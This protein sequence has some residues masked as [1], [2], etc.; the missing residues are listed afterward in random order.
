[1]KAERGWRRFIKCEVLCQN[2][3]YVAKYNL[4][5]TGKK[6]LDCKKGVF[7]V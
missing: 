4:E 2:Q 1:M 7:W 3:G 5:K 6:D